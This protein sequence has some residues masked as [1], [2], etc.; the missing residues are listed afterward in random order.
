MNVNQ[1]AKYLLK[2]LIEK[3]IQDG[4]PVGSK[5]L[6]EQAKEP[7]SPATVRNVL[8]DLERSGYLHSPHTSAGRVP[9]PQAYR[10]FVDSLLTVKPMHSKTVTKLKEKL[11]RD[12]SAHDMALSVSQM[13]SKLT[14]FA[15]IVTLPKSEKFSL[16]QVEF[17]PLSENRVLVILVLNEQEVQNRIIHLDRRFTPSELTQAGNYLTRHYAGKSLYDIRQAL[18]EAMANDKLRMDDRMQTIL[19]LSQKTFHADEKEEAYVVSGK[20]NLA[21]QA[22]DSDIHALLTSFTQKQDMLHLLDNCLSAKGVQ[23][24]I[25]EEAG[26]AGFK[27]ASFVG[28]TYTLQDQTI[29][30]VGV[31][32]PTRMPYNKIIPA[33]DVTA[34]LLSAALTDPD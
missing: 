25:G 14:Q 18:V 23:L 20:S 4:Q 29:G 11:T 7:I 9:T 12:Q 30:V 26:L 16:R 34:R 10:F 24:F 19:D 3:H 27:S 5:L 6:A 31:I 1:R 13:L 15:S 33:V 2:L 21:S 28:T 8:A 22:Q 32:G 17:L